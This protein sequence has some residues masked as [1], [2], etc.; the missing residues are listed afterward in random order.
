MKWLLAAGSGDIYQVTRAFRD[1]E[2]G[3]WHNPEF[4]LLEW[5]RVGFDHWRL[6]DEV[7][8]LVSL[9][10]PGAGEFS[11][12][13]YRMLFLDA[14]DLDPLACTGDQLAAK[15]RAHGIDTA[16]QFDHRAWLDLLFTHLLEPRL[17]GRAVFIHGFPA[18]QAALAR[19]DP[20]D[21]R[22][23]QRFELYVDG[24]ELANGFHELNDPDE[25]RARFAADQDR[26]RAAGLPHVDPDERFLAA[27]EAGMPDCAG[28]ALG[29]DRLLMLAEQA[30][31]IDDVLAFPMERA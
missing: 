5:Y 14:L 30:D 17:A 23:A 4:T 20:D 24:V 25:Q 10:L 13:S 6:M 26:R 7:A 16:G 19:L 27:L 11:W 22:T 28:V 12:I 18:A 2:R 31:C 9:V 21:P 29:L 3:R 8:E 15:A 1:G